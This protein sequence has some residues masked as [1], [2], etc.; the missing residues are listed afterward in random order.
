MS[1]GQSIPALPSMDKF[2]SSPVV[3]S[4]LAGSISGTCSTLLFQPLDLLKTR[5][6]STPRS[7]VG[8]GSSGMVT[9]CLRVL[10]KEKVIGL[11]SG[12]TPSLLR[13]VPGVGLYFCALHTMKSNLGSEN[14]GSLELVA[15]GVGA[16]C[17]AGITMLPFTVVK[18]RFESGNFEYSSVRNALRTIYI[19]EGTRGLYSGMTATL[20]RDAPSSGLYLL[21]YTKAKKL[22][23][24]EK[25]DSSAKPLIHF[26][27]GVMA[28]AMASAVTQ[29]ADVIKTHMQTRTTTVSSAVKYIYQNHGVHGFASGIVPRVIRRT[30]MAALAWTI[31]EQMIVKLGLK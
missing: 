19:A 12:L 17:V 8:Y 3:K 21:F 9:I 25:F 24:S 2:T 15:L 30:M 23:N 28:G 13:C 31:Y 18:V 20:L 14:P 1:V 16:R 29:P 10:R 22:V 26:T 11:W 5:I 7:A 4:F 6:Q 27:C